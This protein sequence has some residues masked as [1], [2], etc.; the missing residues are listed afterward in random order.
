MSELASEQLNIIVNLWTPMNLNWT[1][2][3][4]LSCWYIPI[5]NFFPQCKRYK[6]HPC[7][8]LSKDINGERVSDSF[9]WWNLMQSK[10][11]ILIGRNRNATTWSASPPSSLRVHGRGLRYLNAAPGDIWGPALDNTINVW[12]SWLLVCLHRVRNTHT[13]GET[14]INF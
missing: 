12:H 7:N 3:H 8:F 2:E 1:T 10:W 4:I 6:G 5:T 11:H 13:L 14:N 9:Q